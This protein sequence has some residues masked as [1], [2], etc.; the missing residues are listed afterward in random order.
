MLH[1]HV[2]LF[3]IYVS[4]YI[5]IRAVKRLKY[6]ITINRINAIVNSRLIAIN[7]I[8]FFYAKYPLNSLSH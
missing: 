5:Y 2:K 7:H 4:I 8:I 6:L 1:L 3:Y